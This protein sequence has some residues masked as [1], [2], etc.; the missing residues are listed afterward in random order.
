VLDLCSE[1]GYLFDER[2]RCKC[3]KKKRR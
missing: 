1:S 2:H 3:R